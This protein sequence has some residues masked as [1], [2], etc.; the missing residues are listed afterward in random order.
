MKKY[1]IFFIGLLLALPV[2]SQTRRLPRMSHGRTPQSYTAQLNYNVPPAIGAKRVLALL[3]EF[4]ADSDPRTTGN[5]KFL[6]TQTAARMI[7][8]P[9]YDPSYF[10]NRQ[11]GFSGACCLHTR[12]VHT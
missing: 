10:D 5:G 1:F 4:A 7:D 11:I 8:P 12:Q 2:L 3:V 6:L 9:P